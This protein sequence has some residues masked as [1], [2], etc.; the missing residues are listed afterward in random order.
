MH[1]LCRRL[2]GI[3]VTTVLINEVENITGNFK[4]T[5]ERLSYLTDNIIF[6]RYLEINGKLRKALGVLKKRMSNFENTLR[7]FEITSS[8]IKVGKPL[9]HLRGILLGVPEWVKENQEQL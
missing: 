1:T 9:V 3:G 8:G 6:L 5:E 7:E 4:I 2:R